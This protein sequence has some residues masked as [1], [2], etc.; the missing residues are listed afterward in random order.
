MKATM[1]ID[2]DLDGECD[3]LPTELLEW[4]MEV[5]TFR[6]VQDGEAAVV[7]NTIKVN[8]EE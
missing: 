7:V 4:A 6:T 2:F 1:K 3:D 8:V 5:F